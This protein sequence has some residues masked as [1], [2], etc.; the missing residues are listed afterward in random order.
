MARA[1]R[2]QQKTRRKA[3]GIENCNLEL[4]DEIKSLEGE[5]NEYSVKNEHIQKEVYKLNEQL[6]MTHEAHMNQLTQLKQEKETS[7]CDQLLIQEALRQEVLKLREEYVTQSRQFPQQEKL[8]TQLT[9]LEEIQQNHQEELKNLEKTSKQKMNSLQELLRNKLLEL[10]AEKGKPLSN[11]LHSSL[12]E[13]KHKQTDLIKQ[14]FQLCN[15]CF[16]L[17]MTLLLTKGDLSDSKEGLVQCQKQ[18][19]EYLYVNKL[20]LDNFL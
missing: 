11:D 6:R 7:G 12:E 19:E 5:R 16:E 14:L 2:K 17:E 4:Q 10:Q 15:M 1:V 18:M 8:A 9:Q 20:C 3:K 13:E